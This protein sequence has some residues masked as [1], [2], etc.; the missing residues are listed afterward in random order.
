MR[1][2]GVAWVGLARDGDKWRTL[3]NVAINLQA[4]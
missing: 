1:E 2:G 4:Q 3:V